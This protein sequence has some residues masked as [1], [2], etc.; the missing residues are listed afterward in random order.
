MSN[1]LAIATVTA[2]LQRILQA[3]AQADVPGARVTTVR[4]DSSGSGTPETGVNLYLYQVSPVNWRNADLPTRRANGQVV[5]RPQIA[6]NLSYL[7][8]FYGNEIDLEPQR[9]LGAV[10][11]SLHARPTL[12]TE[13]IRDTI[14]DPMF[15]YLSESDLGD[16]TELVKFLMLPLST[17]DLSKIW[18]VFFQTPYMLSVAYQG[19]VV[20][21]ESDE[22][23]QRAL[24]VRDPRYQLTPHRTVIDQIICI[25]SLP[26]PGRIGPPNPILS[27]SRLSIRGKQLQGPSTYVR[28]GGAEVQ[29]DW[30]TDAELQFSL[31]Q[32][33]VEDLRAGAQGVQVIHREDERLNPHNGSRDSLVL[34]R[35]VESNVAPFILRPAIRAVQIEAVEGDE[36]EPRTGKLRVQVTPHVGQ[37]QRVTLVMNERNPVDPAA[38]NFV[39]LARRE[40]GDTVIVPLREVK[41]GEYLLRLLVDGAESLLQVDFDSRSPTYEQYVAPTVTIP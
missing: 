32:I 13:I 29:P 27:H 28:I 12:T 34:E 33:A 7:M 2:A 19:S 40:D 5:K 4:P 36:E 8:T 30:A 26:K 3:T 41:P 6:L 38:Y 11:R 21:I 37:K 9:L 22:I 35:L 25:D 10:V 31:S 17:E 14:S 23:P 15:D 24:P 20:L 39:A 16:D 18:S 1:H